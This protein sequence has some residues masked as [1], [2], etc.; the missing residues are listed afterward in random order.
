MA[1][2]EGLFKF[3]QF[4]SAVVE[5]ALLSD[6]VLLHIVQFVHETEFDVVENVPDGQLVHTRFV[7]LV[8]LAAIIWPA[9]QFCQ[10]VQ[11][12]ALDEVEKVPSGQ[13]VHTRFAV[14]VPFVET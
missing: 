6:C 9:A 7:V 2:G 3:V 12:N 10:L 1:V 8:P 4:L 13:L 5:P 14:L 11:L